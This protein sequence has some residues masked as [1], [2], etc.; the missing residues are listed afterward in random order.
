MYTDLP[1]KRALSDPFDLLYENLRVD[2]QDHVMQE[3]AR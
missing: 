2:H 3:N 1:N